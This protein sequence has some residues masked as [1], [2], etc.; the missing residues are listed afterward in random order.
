MVVGFLASRPGRW[1]RIVTGAGM[2]VG[3]LAAGTSR[4]AAVALVGLGPLVAAAL[5]WVPAA[6]LFGL[7]MDGPTLRREL[8]VSDEASLLEGLPRASMRGVSPTLH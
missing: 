4:G 8:G 2:V 6:A 1:L 7:P 3:G 5:D